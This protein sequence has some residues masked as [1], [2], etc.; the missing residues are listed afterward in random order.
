MQAGTVYAISC[1]VKNATTLDVDNRVRVGDDF[2][3]PSHEGNAFYY[4]WSSWSSISTKDLIFYVYGDRCAPYYNV[5]FHFN[6]T[7]GLVEIDGVEV[8][9]GQKIEHQEGTVF[10]ATCYA[11]GGNYTFVRYTWDTGSSVNNPYDLTVMEE[12]DF[13]CVFSVGGIGSTGAL[14][15]VV[16]MFVVGIGALAYAL[17]RR[18]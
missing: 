13:Y 5:T 3:S 15:F 2:T 8:T 9:D 14:G 11:L 4:T 12:L 16:F 10:T 6:S 17:M 1:Q 18:L 7:R